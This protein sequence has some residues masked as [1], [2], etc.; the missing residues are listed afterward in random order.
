LRPSR[1]AGVLLHDTE[2][3]RPEPLNPKP[4]QFELAL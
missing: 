1:R 2:A 4:L 3:G